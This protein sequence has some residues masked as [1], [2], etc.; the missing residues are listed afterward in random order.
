MSRRL[1]VL[2]LLAAVA[3]PLYA[4]Y[5]GVE[6][7]LR[8]RLGAPTSIP[9]FGL[10]RATLHLGAP[11]GVHDLQLAVFEHKT[12]PAE[13]V[14]RILRREAPDFKP[15][16]R[17][18]SSRSGEWTFI[19]MRPAPRGRIEMLIVT[20]D[21]DTVLLRM[22]LDAEAFAREV[23]EPRQATQLARR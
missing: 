18:W 19:Y 9:F 22:D 23:G 17:V 3:L 2:A 4:D 15:M 7:A 6:R 8:A 10:V 14:A 21:S 13:D 1:A 20:H 11:D 12:M 5:N 16:V